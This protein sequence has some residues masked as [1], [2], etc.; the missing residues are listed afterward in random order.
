MYIS[1]VYISKV[2]ISV[3]FSNSLILNE[4]TQIYKGLSK[5]FGLTSNNHNSKINRGNEK[6][7]FVKYSPILI[8][9]ID[10]TVTQ[11]LLSANTH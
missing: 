2:R 3:N 8:N 5:K 11:S 10:V 9:L 1:N 7:S 6:I 4:S